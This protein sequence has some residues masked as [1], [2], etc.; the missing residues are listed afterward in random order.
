MSDHP[1]A[2]TGL[3]PRFFATLARITL[4]FRFVVLALLL[5]N[6]AFM[7]YQRQTNLLLETSNEAFLDASSAAAINLEKL[8]DSF[9][10]DEM[11]LVLIEGD[12]FSLDYLSRLK[13]LH[14]ELASIAI[15]VASLG[16]RRA[17]RDKRREMFRDGTGDK[18]AL[19]KASREAELGDFAAAE[20]TLLR[21]RRAAG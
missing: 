12:V 9:G 2:P 17:E 18:A 10:R 1:R 4:R 20:Q 13:K 8:R 14:E 16:E 5:A 15:P 6:S 21:A 11:F 19:A 7:F 3:G